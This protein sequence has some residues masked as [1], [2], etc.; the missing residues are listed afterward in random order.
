MLDDKPNV[1]T[2]TAE[3]THR[4]STAPPM[5]GVAQRISLAAPARVDGHHEAFRCHHADILCNSAVFLR[6]SGW[7][8]MQEWLHE[9]REP[10]ALF[11]ATPVDGHIAWAPPPRQ[12]GR[13]NRS[14]GAPGDLRPAATHCELPIGGQGA[15]SMHEKWVFEGDLPTWAQPL[16]KEQQ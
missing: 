10:R 12:R 11:G 16:A 2:P 4:G 8:P 13:T 6:R 5:A 14:E 1:A 15:V 7:G 9:L 3:L